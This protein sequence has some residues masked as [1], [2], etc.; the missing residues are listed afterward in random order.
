M[1]YREQDV[2]K[3]R[4]YKVDIVLGVILVLVTATLA[5]YMMWDEFGVKV[6]TSFSEDWT[7][8]HL[9]KNNDVP[10][11]EI[12]HIVGHKHRGV[13]GIP[14]NMPIGETDIP[15]S[16]FEEAIEHI[17]EEANPAAG[18]VKFVLWAVLISILIIWLKN[19]RSIRWKRIVILAGTVIV[20]GFFLGAMP[21]PM[22]LVVKLFKWTIGMEAGAKVL[23]TSL[24]LFTI[25]S[26]VMRK[27]VCSWGCP[28]G[29]LQESILNIPVVKRKKNWRL[30]FWLSITMR[31]VLFFVF[32]C[33]LYGI[34]FGVSNFVLYHHVN[35]FKIFNWDLADF[36]LY[37]LP[38]LAIASLF[39]FRP[40]CQFVCPFG[41]YAWVL[42]NFA[43][44]KIYI[45]EDKCVHCEQCVRACPTEAMKGIY[46]K[47]RGYFLPDCW[48][49]GRCIEVCPNNAITFGKQ[50]NGECVA[51]DTGKTKQYDRT[52]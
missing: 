39:V 22:E 31:S 20:F 24:A 44:N 15:L 34:F 33:L 52:C 2:T 40:F 13:W 12:R 6:K 48:S 50:S 10:I 28:L 38:V 7:L 30:P 1:I 26:L 46:A 11:K 19:T 36:A 29:A 35:F 14:K 43:A 18:V 17:R 27:M 16:A 42:E 25:F 49:C 3:I 51:A 45:S 23:I 8:M 21:N 9:A 41:L 37:T 5:L 47:K 32:V 4:K